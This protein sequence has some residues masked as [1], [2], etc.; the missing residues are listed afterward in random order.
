MNAALKVPSENSLLK[1]LGILNA[2][3]NASANGP[4]PNVIAIKKSLIYPRILLRKV[5]KLNV[6]VDLIRFINHISHNLVLI[7]YLIK[8]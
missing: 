1:V 4:D 7:L 2:T 5:K 8:K 6:P 3:K